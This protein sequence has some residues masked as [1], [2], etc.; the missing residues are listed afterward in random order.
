MVRSG[1]LGTAAT[2]PGRC[3]EAAGGWATSTW[4]GGRQV[5]NLTALL[6]DYIAPPR[7]RACLSWA[8]TSP[9]T[10]RHRGGGWYDLA[11]VDDGASLLAC[12]AVSGHT[13]RGPGDHRHGFLL[14]TR[15]SKRPA[16]WPAKGFPIPTIAILA[17]LV[18]RSPAASS[19]AG[20]LPHPRSTTSCRDGTSRWKRPTSW[21]WKA[22]RLSAPRGGAGGLGLAVSD[23]IDFSIYVVRPERHPPLVPGPVPHLKHG[24]H[25][26]GLLLPASPRSPTTLALAGA[27]EI[28]EASTCNLRG[29]ITLPEGGYGS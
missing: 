20:L 21:S 27:N 5:I 4:R 8:W 7:A 2:D 16:S 13:S 14:L 24:L 10:L 29:N 17:G 19:N 11:Q 22:Q 3:R 12:S 18:A 25:P 26:A 6:E 15:S 1:I 9:H 28:W 23:F